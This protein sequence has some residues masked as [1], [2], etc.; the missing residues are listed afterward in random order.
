MITLLY[1]LLYFP[2]VKRGIL[3]VSVIIACTILSLMSGIYMGHAESGS[4]ESVE[5][6]T[7][8]SVDESLT[9]SESGS[10]ISSDI[11]P[12]E[13]GE[14]LLTGSVTENTVSPEV[15]SGNTGTSE[16]VSQTSDNVQTL[17]SESRAKPAVQELISANVPTLANTTLGTCIWMEN[18]C[19]GEYA[20]LSNTTWF[21]NVAIW[22]KGALQL[23]TTWY[24]NIAIGNSAL[25]HNTT[26]YSNVANG[27][28]SLSTNTTGNYNVANGHL[29]LFWN[30]TGNN[31]VANGNESLYSNSSGDFNIGIWHSAGRNITTGSNN[32]AIGEYSIVFSWAM[33]NQLSIGN[34]IYGVSGNIGIGVINPTTKLDIDGQIRIRGGE[35]GSGKVLVSDANGLASWITL[36]T[37]PSFSTTQLCIGTGTWNICNGS[38]TLSANT[39]GWWNIA[40]GQKSLMSNTIGNSNIALGE[41][42]LQW[43]QSWVRN[44]AF[45][46]YS[47][48]SNTIGYDNASYWS[49]SLYSNTVGAN[50]TALGNAS[51]YSN[52]TGYN[53]TSIGSNSLQSNTSWNWNVANGIN[54]LYLNT[55]GNVNIGIGYNAGKNITIGSNNIA[56]GNESQVFSGTQDNQLSLG[57]L[58]YGIGMTGNG[59]G[60]V[61]I[62]VANPTT[63]LDIDGQIRIRGGSVGSGKVLTSD[64]NGLASWMTL[65]TVNTGTNLP[66]GV[67]GNILTH[68]GSRW[69]ASG[70]VSIIGNSIGIGT[71]SPRGLFDVRGWIANSSTSGK[72]IYLTAESASSGNSSGGTIF[73]NP[74]TKSGTGVA[75]IVAI[76][77]TEAEI[78][79]AP[80]LGNNALYSKGYGYF[81][82]GYIAGNNY[83][84]QWGTS[85]TRFRWSGNNNSTDYISLITNNT[86]RFRISGSGN[87]GIGTN[88]PTQLLTL[89]GGTIQIIN[90]SQWS[91][92]VLFSFDL[93][94][95]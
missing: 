20:L 89:S 42:S 56:I 17:I 67:R 11:F 39:N 28:N 63:K 82:W 13:S 84:L 9:P 49:L 95:W 57:N 15:M 24:A 32:I 85:S 73:L 47:L 77:M 50:N 4:I 45:G 59:V 48:H 91:G 36:P 90:G 68:D 19:I 26:G 46:V 79:A 43:N 25:I 35:A 38:G 6:P 70:E 65:P 78:N 12:G 92:K 64:A 94:Q 27:F 74:G 33:D 1:F 87:I 37:I 52:T 53:N 66:S 75:G 58:I 72:S 18:I 61:G 34:W 62:G 3:W 7:V 31:N 8:I 55:K 86:E 81:Q 93:D 30:S 29:A 54:A 71:S 88:N 83:G 2:M 5:A 51:L 76:G 16:Q 10:Q 14:S 41:W 40:I 21:S 80:W 22:W 23:N 44:N 69:I 60:N